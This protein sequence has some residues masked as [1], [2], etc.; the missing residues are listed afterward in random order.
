MEVAINSLSSAEQHI[1]IQLLQKCLPGFR[2]TG[3]ESHAF[4]K[5]LNGHV[6]SC[7]RFLMLT[8]TGL[9]YRYASY[10]NASMTLSPNW[11][12]NPLPT[13]A[14]YEDEPA[15][16]QYSTILVLVKIHYKAVSLVA[17]GRGNPLHGR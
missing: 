11:P 12:N 3:Q 13:N 5:G 1:A 16:D 6:F 17:A 9:R 15:I 7:I 8:T 14:S 2:F 10:P 4:Q